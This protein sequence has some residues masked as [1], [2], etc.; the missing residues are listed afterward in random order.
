[1]DPELFERMQQAALRFRSGESDVEEIMTPNGLARLVRDPTNELGF[2]IDFVGEGSK[3]SVAIQ[4]Y[5]ASPSRPHGYPAPLPFLPGARAT[6]DTLAQSVSWHDPADPEEAF[7]LVA[8]ACLDDGWAEVSAGADGAV[9]EKEGVERRLHL[10]SDPREPS[11]VLRE[12][13]LAPK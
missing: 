9:F 1:M 7:R 5:P 10:S 3:H 6:V 4:S 2:R 11:L 8:R 13:R 12:R